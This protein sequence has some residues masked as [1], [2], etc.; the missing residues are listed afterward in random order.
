MIFYTPEEKCKVKYSD[1]DYAIKCCFRWGKILEDEESKP[2]FFSKTD[3]KSAFRVV[4][5]KKSSWRW[6]LMKCEDPA[7]GGTLFFF[8]KNL[9]FGS[10]I[11]CS[12]FQKF[13]CALHHIVIV[14]TGRRM[15]ITNYLDDFLFVSTSVRIYN[16]LVNYFL[17]ICAEIVVPVAHE[18]TEWAASKTVF[19]GILLDGESHTMYILRRRDSK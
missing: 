3:L 19:L 17:L 5:L 16:Y 9:P 8:D 13:M 7:S 10:S 12:H 18:K 15:A 4:P 1:L 11:S 6:L 14:R 2:L